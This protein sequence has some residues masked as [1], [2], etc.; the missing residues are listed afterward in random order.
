MHQDRGHKD[1]EQYQ[2]LGVRIL[3]VFC[4]KTIQSWRLIARQIINNYR[5]LASVYSHIS[6]KINVILA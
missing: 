3:H 5:H 4:C 1:R 2:E 6:V